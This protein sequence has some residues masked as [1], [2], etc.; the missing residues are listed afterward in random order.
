MNAKFELSGPIAPDL[1]AVRSRDAGFQSFQ[2][3]GRK[4][5]AAPMAI[6][7]R[8]SALLG[9]LHATA[10]PAT[11][12]VLPPP[13]APARIPRPLPRATPTGTETP[14]VRGASNR[15][16][17]PPVR[18]PV[19]APTA[20]PAV[21][22]TAD[23]PNAASKRPTHSGGWDGCARTAS[24]S[25]VAAGTSVVCVASCFSCSTC[26]SSSSLGGPAP[27]HVTDR[28]PSSG[29][30]QPE[31]PPGVTQPGDIS[32]LAERGVAQAGFSSKPSSVGSVRAAASAT[33]AAISASLADKLPMSA[34]GPG[35]GNNGIAAAVT[36]I[37]GVCA[38][39]T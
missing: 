29:V 25:P 5:S 32:R 14:N 38:L 21:P 33:S 23:P 6:V 15:P 34:L 26:L 17:A 10:P 18:P 24:I 2:F 37:A 35:P 11:N 12:P 3:C 36:A 9:R 1:F 13:A 4:R 16:H 19:A 30:I 20:P 22:T 39:N 8:R 7:A 28:L 31:S 27:G